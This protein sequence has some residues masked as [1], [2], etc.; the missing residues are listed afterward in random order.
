MKINYD[1]SSYAGTVRGLYKIQNEAIHVYFTT[2]HKSTKNQEY[3]IL[4]LIFDK[5]AKSEA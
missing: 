2:L 5:Y 4:S 3:N 1:F